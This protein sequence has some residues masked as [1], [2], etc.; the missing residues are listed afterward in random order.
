[1]RTIRTPYACHSMAIFTMGM[2]LTLSSPKIDRRGFFSRNRNLF[3]DML[4]RHPRWRISFCSSFSKKSS[5]EVISCFS[6][7]VWGFFS[8]IEHKPLERSFP[9]HA[10]KLIDTSF[11]SCISIFFNRTANRIWVIHSHTR[12]KSR[13]STLIAGRKSEH[14]KKN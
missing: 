5:H 14:R 7:K 12:A 9:R 10:F 8:Y 11:C 6:H 3:F 4:I 2:G 13:A 1:M